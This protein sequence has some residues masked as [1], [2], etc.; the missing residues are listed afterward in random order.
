MNILIA[1]I[2]L[3]VLVFVHEYLSMNLVILL[4]QNGRGFM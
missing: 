3:G 1:I 2:V 4:W